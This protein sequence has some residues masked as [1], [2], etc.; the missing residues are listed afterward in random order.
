MP[1]LSID[2]LPENFADTML[3]EIDAA[4]LDRKDWELRKRVARNL[5]YGNA[6]RLD[7]HWEGA[8]DIHMPVVYDK[9]ESMVPK[10]HNSFFNVEPKV[11]VRRVAEEYDSEDTK[12]QQKFFNWALDHDIPHFFTTTIAW[13]RNMLLDGVGVVKVRWDKC[14]RNTCEVHNLKAF[15]SAGEQAQGVR[16]AQGRP[17]TVLEMLDELFKG[18]EVVDAAAIEEMIYMVSIIESRREISGIRV[19]FTKSEF[20]D[21]VRAYVYRPVLVDDNPVVEVIDAERLILPYRACQIQQADWVAHEYFLRDDDI[22]RRL[23]DEDPWE[24]DSEQIERLKKILKGGREKYPE[25]P[26]NDAMRRLKDDTTGIYGENDKG[27]GDMNNRIRAYEIYASLDVD[28]DGRREE[29][30]VQLIPDLKAIVHVT[31]LEVVHPHGHRPF[32]PIHFLSP[33]DRFYTPGIAEILAPINIQVNTTINQINDAQELQNNPFG[34]YNPAG[35]TVDHDKLQ[36]IPPGTLIP[37]S[38]INSVVF[39]SWG[40]TPLANSNV[41]ESVL[42][43]ADR[44]SVS[45]FSGGNTQVRNAPRTARG[46][47]ALISEGNVKTDLLVA[48]AQ[49]EG[50]QELMFQLAGLYSENLTSEKYFWA[51]GRDKKDYTELIAPQQVRGKYEFAF[52]G[53]TTNTNPE[54]QRT[55]AQIRYQVGVANPLYQFDLPKLKALLRNFYENF[56]ENTNI[57]EYLPDI[58]GDGSQIHP[59]MSQKDE[60]TVMRLGRPIDPLLVDNHAEHIEVI[61]KFMAN[62]E[63]TAGLPPMAVSFI[64][65]HRRRHVMMM[66]IQQQ[67]AALQQ[68]QGTQTGGGEQSANLAQFEGGV[69]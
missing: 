32:A 59:P 2:Q 43:F 24:L 28:G 33:T 49:R 62:P 30:I 37:T 56:S 58:P 67:Q 50:W 47:L 29:L 63:A 52:T 48:M 53:N 36:N 51:T 38:D 25:S 27:R 44:I 13:F 61:D 17:K 9:V 69:Q 55:L 7:V 11:V 26:H 18:A 42:L 22:E 34:F 65:D 31:Y 39:P 19:E 8:S 1:I 20:V 10:L 64:A 35:M 23:Q 68:Q 14:W 6:Q 5:Y 12:I 3:S 16:V 40:T 41:I 45:P 46:T 15:K 21:E 54:V 60:L 66:Q 57:D 4:M